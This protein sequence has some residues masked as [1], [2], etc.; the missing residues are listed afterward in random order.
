VVVLPS[1]HEGLPLVAIET[2]AASRPMVATAVDG[3]PEVIL[4]EQTG[5][6]V[7]P[8]DSAAI[9]S[10]VERL[11]RYPDL[12][13]KLAA[14]GHAYVMQRFDIRMQ[15]E[16]TVEVYREVLRGKSA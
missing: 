3:T 10:A 5:L 9:A 12:G 16:Q 14:A 8:R 13:A 15:L 11:L 2:L 4:D 1:L 6:L 7:P